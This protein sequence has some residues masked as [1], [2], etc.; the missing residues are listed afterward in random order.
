MGG[1]TTKKPGIRAK[2]K[3]YKRS[4]KTAN[5]SKDIDQIQDELYAVQK[6][7]LPAASLSAK[8]YDDELPGGGQFYVWETD[9]H[10]IDEEAM[11]NHKKTREYKRRVKQ[12]QE[13]QY[14][15]DYAERAAGMSKEVLPPV[16]GRSRP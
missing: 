4:A 7:A 9:S 16:G 14:N 8:T 1:K 15:Q 5:R 3:K 13:E 6:A 10:F 2:V 11:N 12:L